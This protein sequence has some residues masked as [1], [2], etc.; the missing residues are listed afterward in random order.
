[1]VL[2]THIPTG[3]GRIR[4]MWITKDGPVQ[5]VRSSKRKGDAHQRY[6][7]RTSRNIDDQIG[8]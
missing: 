3:R 4:V 5:E 7:R 1:M 2:I 8:R 6:S